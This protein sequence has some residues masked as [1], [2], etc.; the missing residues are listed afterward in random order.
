MSTIPTVSV[1][2]PAYNAEPFIRDATESILK[3]TFA[4]FEFIIINDG[5]TDDTLEILEEL[6]R[7]D[8][9]IRPVSRP[10]TGYTVALNEAL[11]M[12]RGIYLARMDADDVSMP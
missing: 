11:S 7:R 9:R 12:A 3:Q 5:S 8:A 2:M 4:D 6:A 10:N 1:C